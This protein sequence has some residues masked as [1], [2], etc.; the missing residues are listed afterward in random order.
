MRGKSIREVLLSP[1]VSENKC[2]QL[3]KERGGEAIYS[4]DSNVIAVESIRLF[5]SS[6]VCGQ[7]CH[8]LRCVCG[9]RGGGGMGGGVEGG[10]LW[11]LSNLRGVWEGCVCVCVGG[12]P[13]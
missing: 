3:E 5:A 13:L 4:I 8:S 6:K 7:R 12:G 11:T 10:P 9:G 2:R 1:F